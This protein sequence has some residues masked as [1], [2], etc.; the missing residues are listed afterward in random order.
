MLSN[1]QQS[2]N[3]IIPYNIT[4]YRPTNIDYTSYVKRITL[5]TI[6]LI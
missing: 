2:P 5:S 6:E 3:F 1:K 4:D